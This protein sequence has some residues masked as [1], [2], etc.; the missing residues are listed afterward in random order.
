MAFRVY[1][2]QGFGDALLFYSIYKE[3]AKRFGKIHYVSHERTDLVFNSIKRLYETIPEVE[4]IRE[5]IKGWPDVDWALGVGDIWHQTLSP[6]LKNIYLP[7]SE[8][9][10]KDKLNWYYDYYI[11]NTAKVPF[12]LKWDNFYIKRDLKREKEIYYDILGLKDKEEFLFLHEDPSRGY[13]FYE[14]GYYLDRNYLNH[15][16]RWIEMFKLHEYDV[17]L[18]D[19]TYTLER[20]TEIH[21]FSSCVPIFVDLMF[22]EHPGKLYFHYYARKNIAFYHPVFRT[23]WIEILNR[24]DEAEEK[25]TKEPMIYVNYRSNNYNINT[26]K[27][28]DEKEDYEIKEH[29]KNTYGKLYNYD[30]IYYDDNI[31]VITPTG[32]G[33][34]IVVSGAIKELAKRHKTINYFISPF[35]QKELQRLYET[36]P[37]VIL[38]IENPDERGEIQIPRNTLFFG[39]YYFNEIEKRYPDIHWDRIYYGQLKMPLRLKWDNFH[40]KRDLKRE[41]EIYYDIIGLK[42]NE[43]YI[44]IHEDP[45]RNMYIDKKYI[46][47]NIRW[48]NPV[49]FYHLNLNFFDFLYTIERAKEIHVMNSSFLCLI[50]TIELKH[51]NLNYYRYTNDFDGKD[52]NREK[53]IAQLTFKLNWKIK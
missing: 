16:I 11:Y 2:Y 46:P 49:N 23:N 36:T 34:Y 26:E 39:M 45:T 38:R 52:Y 42:D 29:I 8:E 50:D 25:M 32:I 13:E 19:L 17:N 31:S 28:I 24:S 1:T 9:I 5:P 6:W 30:E 27:F 7:L 10:K 37:N 20:A 15:N 43:E 47:R 4:V 21:S 40:I 14:K 3:F 22:K 18:L 12:H 33:D 53:E 51:N 35:Y 48:V 41:K 44:F